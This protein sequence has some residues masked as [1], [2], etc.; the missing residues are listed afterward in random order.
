M[1]DIFVQDNGIAVLREL[2]WISIVLRLALAIICGGIIGI[3]RGRKGRTA[4][5]RTHVLVCIGAALTVLTNQYMMQYFGG[6]DP[7]RLGAQ[8]INGIGF[9]GAGTIIVTGRHKVK[10]L[11]TAA[12]LWACACMGLAIGI[13][14][15]EAA[16][17]ACV[18]ILFV[19]SALHRM[20]NY[21]VSKSKV[22]EIYVEFGT[23]EDISGFIGKMRATDIRVSEIEITKN[24]NSADSSVAAVM[25]LRS[26]VKRDHA[27]ILAI[28]SDVK[29][30]KFVEYI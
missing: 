28:A 21:V 2:N 24:T 19:N 18:L 6:G 30:V 17:A 8:V 4:G 3:E 23:V 15:Y 5:F 1:S 13:G 10:G 11:T 26:N 16:I 27:E 14:F 12:G 25:L 22:V 9:L 7:A 20:D 29:G